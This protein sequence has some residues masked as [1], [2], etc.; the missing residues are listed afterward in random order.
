[1]NPPSILFLN[2]VYP[3]A[4]GA[5]GQLLAELAT[6]LARRGYSVSIIAS[7]AMAKDAKSQVI[8]GVRV[9]RVGG[10]PFT[11]ASH[12]RR[13]LSY[14]S[15]Y[16]AM[17]WRTL[18]LPRHDIVVTL[19]DP[20]LQLLLGPLLQWCKGSKTVHWAQDIYPELA[21]EM[22][23]LPKDGLIARAL[24]HLSTWALR[25]CDNVIAV[26]QC[27]KARLVQRGIAAQSIAV[28]PNWGHSANAECGTRNADSL[29]SKPEAKKTQSFRSE[30]E[31]NG[32]FVVMYSGNLGLAHPFE[33]I[34]EA[35]E[36]LLSAMPEAVFLFVGNG[37][38]LP[39][40]QNQVKLRRLTNVRFVPFQPKENLAESLGAA[41]LHLASMR[42]ELCGLVVPSKVSGV[43]AAGRPC[44]FLGPEESE[45]AQLI[46]QHACGSVLAHAT[47]ARLAACI[48]QW[49]RHPESLREARANA[50]EAARRV[51]LGSAV[52]QFRKLFTQVILA[53]AQKSS[54]GAVPEERRLAA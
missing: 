42:H 25:R 20:P 10:L 37:P 39:W 50:L 2:R 29:T 5:T 49:A 6:E 35:A 46:L 21:E 31:L 27:M 34:L 9:E 15:L 19:T 7:R 51:N 38:R 40:V 14:L 23:V 24:R 4:E 48:S 33:A 54:A 22:G 11:R 28:V 36:R 1:M 41:D 43:L 44:V 47:G 16:P 32:K 12:L 17:L 3:P 18:R 52:T 53:T 30:H 45:A 26:G 8:D 13:A